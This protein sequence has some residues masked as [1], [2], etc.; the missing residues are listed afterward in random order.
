MI[1]IAVVLNYLLLIP[2]DVYTSV[3]HSDMRLFNWNDPLTHHNWLPRMYDLYLICYILLLVLGFIF[4]PF[5]MF[6]VWSVQEEDDII[7]ENAI[8]SQDIGF[9]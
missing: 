9:G 3:H 1:S 4:V 5:Q 6:Y 7:L 2:F 8:V